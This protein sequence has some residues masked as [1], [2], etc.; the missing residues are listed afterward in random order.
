MQRRQASGIRARFQ[1]NSA[2]MPGDVL[3]DEM[4][5]DIPSN[6]AL[7]TPSLGKGKKAQVAQVSKQCQRQGGFC[8]QIFSFSRQSLICVQN[9]TQYSG[10][11]WIR[12]AKGQL[13]L[14]E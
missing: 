9:S 5:D 3:K 10:Y 12:D 6:N 14:E 11:S 4:P 1:A 7:N 13:L 8:S 2:A